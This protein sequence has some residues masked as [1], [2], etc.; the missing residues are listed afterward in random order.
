MNVREPR[1][2]QHLLDEAE[3]VVGVLTFHSRVLLDVLEQ[4]VG[5]TLI[6]L[7]FSFNKG[8]KLK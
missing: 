5:S 3:N 4:L 7:Y 1:S 8:L 2:R 6:M